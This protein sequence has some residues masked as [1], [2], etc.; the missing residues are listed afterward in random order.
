MPLG[1]NRLGRGRL[2]P[3]EMGK[4]YGEDNDRAII[5]TA[6]TQGF[7]RG[8]GPPCCDMCRAISSEKLGFTEP[9]LPRQK[10]LAFPGEW[11]VK[12]SARVYC[13]C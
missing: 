4:H 3:A 10:P 11:F 13:R 6:T 2:T 5:R 8:G 7:G 9:H 1:R 12:A